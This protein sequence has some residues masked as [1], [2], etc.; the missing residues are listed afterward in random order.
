MPCC[1][2]NGEPDVK[3][4]RSSTR[5]CRWAP[6][7]D[8][9]GGAA[10]QKS[11]QFLLLL[12]RRSARREI[13]VWR[14]TQH[15]DDARGGEGFSAGVTWGESGFSLCLS[16]CSVKMKSIKGGESKAAN[17]VLITYVF[18][19]QAKVLGL[20]MEP[21][22]FVSPGEQTLT[23]YLPLCFGPTTTTHCVSLPGREEKQSKAKHHNEMRVGGSIRS[24]KHAH[25]QS[26]CAPSLWKK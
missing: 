2:P 12:R 6:V 19:G 9:W 20:Q 14:L 13:T 26:H 5:G 24:S 3:S 7:E 10:R 4:A 18:E 8:S 1:V 17:A 22:A 21:F 23:C 25:Q 15:S 16:L 11:L